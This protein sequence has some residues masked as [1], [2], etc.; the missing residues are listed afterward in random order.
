MLNEYLEPVDHSAKSVTKYRGMEQYIGQLVDVPS[1]QVYAAYISKA[2]NV[3]VRF[4]QSERSRGARLLVAIL[5]PPEHEPFSRSVDALRSYCMR[6]R[7]GTEALVLMLVNDLWSPQTV[8]LPAPE[9]DQGFALLQP[10]V[11]I[12][13]EIEVLEYRTSATQTL[14]SKKRQAVRFIVADA[15]QHIPTAMEYPFVRLINDNWDDYK[16]KTTFHAELCLSPKE[17]TQLGELKV[18]QRNQHGGRTL[19]PEGVFDRLGAEYCSLGQNFEYYETLKQFPKQVYDPILRGLRDVVRDERILFAFEQEEGFRLSLMRHGS[20]ARALQDAPG[21]FGFNEEESGDGLRF[22]FVT[23]VGGESFNIVLGFNQVEVL[24]DNINVVIGY[25]GTGKTQLLANLALVASADSTKREELRGSAGYFSDS[26]DVRFGAVICIS[27]S[28]FDT[29]ALP[30][31]FLRRSEVSTGTQRLK[32]RGEINDYTYCGLRK[33]AD[34]QQL[35][36]R[37]P[38][39]LKT[40]DEVHGDFRRALKRARSAD[41]RAALIAALSIIGR[42]PSF[43]RIGLEPHMAYYDQTWHTYFEK[44]STGHKI[45][46]NMLVQIIAH[47]RP[48]SLILIDEPESHLHPSLLAAFLRAL[49]GTLR[50]FNSYA[51]IATHSPV[52][53]QEMPRNQVRIL[54]R[55][56]SR[57][58]VQHPLS[59]TFGENVGYLTSNVFNLDNT[60]TDYH[61]VLKQLAENDDLSMDDIEE[62]FDGEL[63]GQARAYVR[64]LRAIARQAR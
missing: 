34:E 31:S 37:E 42:E 12:W 18:L 40:I 62:L 41:K 2:G 38:R 52:V 45:V 15:R 22:K 7:P 43:G 49:N 11:D 55:F 54:T 56:G 14:R 27:Y 32:D 60:Q 44:L 48:R 9:G 5:D 24:P 6:K 23:N 36:T 39:G 29:F 57:T 46:L 47:G 58:I 19:L 61:S 25:N 28:A 50:R 64:S 20:A 30:E 13:P 10:V 1:E 35:D 4:D 59:E 26:N 63:S 17:T 21:L 16:F 8:I 33:R 3:S 53:L 51:V